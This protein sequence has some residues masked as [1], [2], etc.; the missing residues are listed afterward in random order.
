M[1]PFFAV[2]YTAQPVQES[3]AGREGTHSSE[4]MMTSGDGTIRLEKSAN[5]PWP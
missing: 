1:V 3:I 2:E 5:S 4:V